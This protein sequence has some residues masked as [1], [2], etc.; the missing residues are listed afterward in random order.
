M[1]Q[2]NVLL[3]VCAHNPTGMCFCPE[4]WKE[5]ATVVK[6]NNLFAFFGMAYQGFV[7][8]DGN[9]DAW[10]MCHFIFTEQGINI[11]LYQSDA[12]NMGLYSE[13]VGSFTVVCKDTD[14]AKRV[15]SQL[16]ILICPMYSNPPI[17]GAC[18]ALTI[19]TSPDL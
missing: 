2:Q 10:A 14:E 8:G 5:V 7:S 17:S 6:K 1:L 9:K 3:H 18:I 13:H 4:Q 19:L 16:K 11:C 15:E 12:K